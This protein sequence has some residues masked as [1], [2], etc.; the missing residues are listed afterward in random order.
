MHGKL[1]RSKQ[2][3]YI[4]ITSCER[5]LVQV[6]CRVVLSRFSTRRNFA[7]RADFFF[8]FPN[9]SSVREIT[10]QIRKIPHRARKIPPSEKP[11]LILK[12]YSD[13]SAALILSVYL[14]CQILILI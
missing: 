11:A 3:E 8:V 6:C 9:Y 10:R 14:T 5:A 2:C 7:R 1:E 13:V 4:L 12:A